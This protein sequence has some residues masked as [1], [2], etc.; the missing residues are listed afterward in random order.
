MEAR[1]RA[2]TLNND[3][4]VCCYV[5]MRVIFVDTLVLVSSKIK[6]RCD[7]GTSMSEGVLCV[8]TPPF[9]VSGSE[10]C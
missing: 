7:R 2:T 8:L 5:N 4:T 3:D 10:K 9:D 6:Y 1:K